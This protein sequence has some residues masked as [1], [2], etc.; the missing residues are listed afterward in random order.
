MINLS[1]M[2]LFNNFIDHTKERKYTCPECEQVYYSYDQLVEHVK[3]MHK[4]D[5]PEGDTVNQFIYDGCHPGRPKC[6]SCKKNLTPWN[7][8]K[9]HYEWYCSPACRKVAVDRLKNPTYQ[10]K[11][12]LGRSISG[13]Y[14]FSTG[15]RQPFVGS[16]AEDF[17]R[18]CDNELK[19]RS[20]EI[21]AEVDNLGIF[22]NFR[23]EKCAYIPDYY[24]PEY[25]L[26]IEIKD[27]G[28]N[29]N[30][31]PGFAPNREREKSKDKTLVRLKKY[32]YIKVVN[33]EYY[34][35]DKLIGYF[36]NLESTDQIDS[37]PIIIIPKS[38]I[39]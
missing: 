30:T 12:L 1:R 17:L 13:T 33:K 14:E 31:H 10:K 7:E 27:G 22:Y 11:M 5:I 20:E 28:N 6:R 2:F 37:K 25:N 19:I 21:L 26:I 36:R 9:M 39:V 23:G 35:F 15:G 38:S 32:N 34:D 4:S 29:P 16:Y 24:M 3:K 18:H 8:E